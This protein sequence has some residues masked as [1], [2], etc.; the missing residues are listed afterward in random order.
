[1][2]PG[3]EPRGESGSGGVGLLAEHRPAD[4]PHDG[5]AGDVRGVLERQ[6]RGVEGA[7]GHRAADIP[8]GAP[9]TRAV[10]GVMLAIDDVI[11]ALV[12][13]RDDA[14]AARLENT[15]RHTPGSLSQTW[16]PN[17]RRV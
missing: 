8:M 17:E 1:M 2:R 14:S 16:G 3:E 7:F 5:A 13:L 6:S 10:I 4:G 12:S 9:A 15:R 11:A